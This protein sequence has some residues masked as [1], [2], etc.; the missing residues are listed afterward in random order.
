M[1]KIIAGTAAAVFT[2]VALSAPAAANPINDYLEDVADIS[3]MAIT[4]TNEAEF[5]VIGLG[6]C[7]DLLSGFTARE[8]YEEIVGFGLTPSQAQQLIQAAVVDLCPNA[9]PNGGIA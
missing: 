5:V 6:I 2:A 1:N 4:E 8:E 7:V 3:G 9:S